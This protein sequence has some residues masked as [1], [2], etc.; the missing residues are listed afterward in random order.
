MRKHFLLA[1]AVMIAGCQTA[2]TPIIFKPGVD[3]NQTVAAVDQCKIDSFKEIPQS[4]ATD[5]DPGYSSPGT[6]Q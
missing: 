6:E 1:S 4:M 2:P 3:L 5:I